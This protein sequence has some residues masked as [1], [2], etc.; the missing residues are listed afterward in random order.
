MELFVES[1]KHLCILLTSAN[2][3]L[4]FVCEVVRDVVGLIAVL[5]YVVQV[6]LMHA[7]KWGRQNVFQLN[8]VG[9]TLFV[10]RSSAL[11]IFSIEV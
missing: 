6:L 7:L 9:S 1:S 8:L 10:K 3:Y 5:S 4:F 11:S 2:F